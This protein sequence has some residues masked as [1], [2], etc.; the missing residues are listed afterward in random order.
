M[1]FDRLTKYA[2]IVLALL[3][4]VT[5]LVFLQ[6]GTQKLFDFPAFPPRPGGAPSGGGPDP[7]MMTLMHIAGPL[8]LIGGLA[9]L[10]GVLTRPVAFILA[11]ECAVIFWIAHVPRGG[12]FPLING[13]EPAVLFC[14]IYLYFVFAGPGAWSIDGMW[15]RRTAAVTTNGPEAGAAAEARSRSGPAD[16]RNKRGTRACRRHWAAAAFR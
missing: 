1:N 4:I 12:I 15:S 9:M 7:L 2:P 5:A 6:H 3:R 13:G 10:L 14:F 16:P 8:E 11:G